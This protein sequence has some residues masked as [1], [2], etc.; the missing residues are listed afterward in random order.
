MLIKLA[1]RNIWRNK[2]RTSILLGAMVFGLISVIAMIGFMNSFYTN[3]IDNTIKWQTSHV[4][5]HDVRYPDDPDINFTIANFDLLSKTLNQQSNINAWTSRFLVN[6]M[7]A[8][9]RSTRGVTINGI[10]LAT[11]V[12]PLSSKVIAGEWM[13]ENGRNPIMVS[14]KTS[15]RLNL[16]VGSKVVL[17]FSDGAG[18]VTGAAFRV[19]GIFQTASSAMDDSN[20]YVRKDNLRKISNVVGIHEVAIMFDDIDDAKPFISF[21]QQQF[22]KEVSATWIIRDWQ[23]LNPVLKTMMDSAGAFNAVFLVIFVI[24]MAFGIVNILLMSVFERT[25]EFGVLMAVGMSKNKIRSVIILESALMGLCGTTLGLFGAIM[26][27]YSLAKTGIDLNS[28]G[29]SLQGFGIDTMLYPSVSF[30][31]YAS[32]FSAV[33]LAVLLSGLYP[34]HKILQ[35]QPADAMSEKH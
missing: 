29:D 3:M 15:E 6:G 14:K 10:D 13:D 25:R 9:A 31:E 7:I 18:E 4:K 20:V 1:W 23:T 19:R 30:G 35:Q 26:L 27:E 28:F 5:I 16:R 22:S 24:A 33:M 32:A 2:L 12:T 11:E 21:L 34:A 17:T 8:S